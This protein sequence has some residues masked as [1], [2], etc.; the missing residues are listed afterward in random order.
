MSFE[1]ESTFL[2]KS[3]NLCSRKELIKCLELTVKYQKQCFDPKNVRAL[4]LGKIE[5]MKRKEY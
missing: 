1:T 2:G 5:I 4:A 3:L